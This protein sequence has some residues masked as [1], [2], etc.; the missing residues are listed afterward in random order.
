MP[1]RT[2]RDADLLGFEEN[3]LESIARTFRDRVEVEDGIVFDPA[4]VS[5]EEIRKDAD[6]AGARVL[7]TGEIAKALCKTQMDIWFGARL[8]QVLLKT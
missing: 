5:A 2:T 7:I 3:D 1:H 4:S 6:Y 8:R